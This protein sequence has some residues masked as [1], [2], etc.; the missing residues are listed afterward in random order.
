MDEAGEMDVDFLRDEA[1]LGMGAAVVVPVEGDAA[2]FLEKGEGVDNG[3]IIGFK[4]RVGG[5]VEIVRGHDPLSVDGEDDFVM[6]IDDL[7]GVGRG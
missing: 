2:K 7:E 6:C 4:A 5:L 3:L 1:V